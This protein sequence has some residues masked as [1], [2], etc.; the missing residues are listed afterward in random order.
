[1]AVYSISDHG[2]DFPYGVTVTIDAGS[3]DFVSDEAATTFAAGV[4]AL[5]AETTNQ[6]E[7]AD[8]HM[9][10]QNTSSTELYP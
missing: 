4:V 5:L 8:Y 6:A 7:T 9:I 10:R 2:S 3:A 1:M